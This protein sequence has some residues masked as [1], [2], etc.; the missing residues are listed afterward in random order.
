MSV[1][2]LFSVPSAHA[3]C[4]RAATEGDLD[5]L[6]G[7]AERAY[8]ELDEPGFRAATS[9]IDAGLACV[10]EVLSPE[11]IARLH[12]VEGLGAWLAKKADRTTLAFAAAKVAQPAYRFPDWLPAASPERAA[13]ER[14]PTTQ[15]DRVPLPP[16]AD[17]RLYVDGIAMP[18]RPA[19]WPYVL[20]VVDDAGVPRTSAYLWPD[21]PLP[22][23]PAVAATPAPGPKKA[24]RAAPVAALAA[25]LAATV[26][27]SALYGSAWWAAS[28]DGYGALIDARDPGANAY[29]DEHVRPRATIGLSLAIAGGVATAGS[30][31][32]LAL[33]GR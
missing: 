13:Y 6:A 2:V 17:G 33:S 15:P 4:E 16:P 9:G 29:Y 23:Y 20:Q 19:T 25:S 28:Q 26:A 31:A 5:A 1:L 14:A 18:D 10:G 8:A 24:G 12:R 7:A 22:A 32:W 27:G 11:L 3:A 30:G 21:E